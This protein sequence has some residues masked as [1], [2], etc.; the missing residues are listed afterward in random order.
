MGQ[1]LYRTYRSRSLAEVVGQEHITDTLGR[2][3]QAGRI[4]HAYLFT[5]PR[6]VGKTSVAR[7][8]AHEINKLPYGDEPHLDIIEI[9]AASNRRIDD[10]RDLRDKVHITPIAAAYKIYIIDEV[11]MLTG[12]SF[13]A[14]LKTLEEPPAHVVFILATTEA[15]KLPA[16]I[17]SRTQ[18]YSFR[19]VAKP[20][21]IEHLAHIAKAEHINITSD[22][23]AL[24]AEHGEGSFRDSISLLDQ[25]ANISGDKITAEAVEQNLGLAPHRTVTGLIDA[26]VSSDYQALLTRLNQLDDQGVT[27]SS[28]IPQLLRSLQQTAQA[29]PSLYKVIDQLLDVPRA[30]DP[31]LKL[32]TVLLGFVIPED[33]PAPRQSASLAAPPV[34]EIAKPAKPSAKLAAKKIPAGT[35]QPHTLP[36][37][38]A[39]TVMQPS[40]KALP[41]L[42]PHQW[43]QVLAKV[44][45]LSSPLGSILKHAQPAYNTASNTLTLK[46]KFSI[47]SKRLDDAKARTLLVKALVATTGAAPIITTALDT[48]AVA[49]D[50]PAPEMDDTA[51]SVAEL[52]GGGEAVHA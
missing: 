5:G 47:H 48:S 33:T 43:A 16:T 32:R 1:A 3:L 18:R 42:T 27:T 20:K 13:N 24:I 25:L 41:E 23:L 46:F 22:A 40:G 4:S 6:G 50:L 52:M 35:A 39:A 31:K 26:L 17:I 21:V 44:T 37:E 12:E 9:D 36:Q 34:F 2:A 11:H 28:L 7:I 45:T 51:K 19:P 30:F 29:Q 14:L 8:L 10:I 49:P 15:H 38:P